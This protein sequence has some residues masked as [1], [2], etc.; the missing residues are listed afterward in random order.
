MK[1]PAANAAEHP[2]A[3]VAPNVK[4]SQERRVQNTETQPPLTTGTGELSLVHIKLHHTDCQIDRDGKVENYRQQGGFFREYG[5][6]V[7]QD[8][9]GTPSEAKSQWKLSQKEVSLP[10]PPLEPVAES[11][12]VLQ[13]RRIRFFDHDPS[14]IRLEY[15]LF[16]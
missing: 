12:Y 15:A 10:R 4:D 7:V 16:F 3:N 14:F 9:Y 8:L 13:D 2:A 1:Q 5:P 11:R 6:V